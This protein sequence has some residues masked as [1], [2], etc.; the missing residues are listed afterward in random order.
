[1]QLRLGDK[2]K[3]KVFIILAIFIL[4]LLVKYDKSE[5][6]FGTDNA[7]M[8][9]AFVGT[10]SCES[11]PICHVIADLKSGNIFY[12]SNPSYEVYLKGKFEKCSENEYMLTGNEI[13]SQ[14]IIIENQRFF[15]YIKD[16]KLDFKKIS[17][18]PNYSD[19][20]EEFAK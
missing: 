9:K 12:Y 11:N 5:E 8:T 6:I 17:E 7:L 4:F 10:Y 20:I 18:I 3:K 15:L 14:R 13:E 2:M 1:M 19:N 16:E